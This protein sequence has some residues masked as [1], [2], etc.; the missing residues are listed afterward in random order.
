MWIDLHTHSSVSDGTQR[1]AEVMRSA[2]LAGLDVLAL[3]DH[4]TTAGWQQAADAV[5]HTGVS[6]VRGTEISTKSEGVSVHLLSY[7]HDP[8]DEAL[9]QF[10]DRTRA[11]RSGRAQRMVERIA[12][13]YPL[14]WDEVL[15]QVED[16]AT[17][18]RP[19]LADALIARGYVADRSAAF[20]HIL[21]P[22]GPYF[23]PHWAPST[24]DA[25]V[26]VRAAGGVPVLAHP[27]SLTRGRVVSDHT[28]AQL[29]AVGLAG[30]EVDHPDHDD[31][32]RVD[33]RALVADLGLLAT[34]SS[35]YHGAGKPTGLGHCTTEP[36]VL[37]QIAAAGRIEILRP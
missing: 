20:A 3:T 34:G 18:G 4:D 19:H 21:S 35:D 23:Q 25:V 6:L 11:S 22:A 15:D 17:V 10:F 28:I 37:D 8:Q 27:R 30:V 5:A 29:A 32:D 1:P 16:G 13:D 9:R 26:A 14:T 36:Q 24:A 2:A 12:Q 31:A 33:L 7:L